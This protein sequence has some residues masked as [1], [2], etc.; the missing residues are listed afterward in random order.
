M[1]MFS[2]RKAFNQYKENKLK[3]QKLEMKKQL[4]KIYDDERLFLEKNKRA[5]E[6]QQSTGHSH[7]HENKGDG[8]SHEKPEHSHSHN[9]EKTDKPATEIEKT[10]APEPKKPSD[11]KTDKPATK[12]TEKT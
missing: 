12:E 11:E 10:T 9:H 3:F 7:S 2:G 8:H 1:G 4:T 6:I 5:A